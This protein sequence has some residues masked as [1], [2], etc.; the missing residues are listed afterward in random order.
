MLHQIQD[1]IVDIVTWAPGPLV[2]GG[3]DNKSW[4]GLLRFASG[5]DF[6]ELLDVHQSA[7]GK[8]VTD[9]VD[10]CLLSF[11]TSSLQKP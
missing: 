7:H 2:I 8:L 11:L 4:V 9:Q 10:L 3:G 1:A 6:D 5:E